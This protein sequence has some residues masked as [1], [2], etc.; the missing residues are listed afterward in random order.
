MIF[1]RGWIA[2][3]AVM[4]ACGVGG[5]RSASA[6]EM[7]KNVQ[8]VHIG[9]IDLSSI[10]TRANRAAMLDGLALDASPA[11][12]IARM[13]AVN[14]RLPATIASETTRA[15]LPP[16]V[17]GLKLA[18]GNLP[19]YSNF[20]GLDALD[21]DMVNPG[22][23]LGIEPPDQGLCVGDGMVV[24]I[25]N[26]AF[27]T[28]DMSG[29]LQPPMIDLN[30]L[31]GVSPAD[32]LSDP[33]CYYDKPSKTFFL[34]V[35]DLGASDP[36]N[37][38]WSMTSSL[39]IAVMPAGGSTIN[40]YKIDS[41]DPGNPLCPCFE[42]QPLLG[43]DEYGIYISGNEF[44]LS[45]VSLTDGALIFAIN[46]SDL[47]AGGAAGAAT[48]ASYTFAYSVQP[49]VPAQGVFDTSNNG[50]E[51]LMS[52]LD[53][54]ATS[55]DRIALWAITNTCGIPSGNGGAACNLTPQLSDPTIIKTMSY[56]L[57]SQ[58]QQ[59]R[60][61]FP[62]GQW[63]RNRF[64]TIDSGDDRMQQVVFAGGKLYAG[65]TTLL[66]V[67]GRPH[68]GILY[69]IVR[70]S[71]SAGAPIADSITAG[72]AALAGADLYY[73]SIAVNTNGSAVMAFSMSGPRHF[74][75]SAYMPLT[76]DLGAPAIHISRPG[77]APYD[78]ISG[79]PKYG[80]GPP[81]RWG[82]YSAAFADDNGNLWIASE[83]TGPSC[84]KREWLLDPTHT[85]WGTR[86]EYAN[87][88]TNIGEITV[89]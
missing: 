29:N 34:T 40:L 39:R 44:P 68:T 8:V 86:G 69:F 57:P 53:F 21:S 5:V 11:R 10:R 43:A 35:T 4:A 85:C 17:A 87:W 51:Y 49:A 24:E 42:D 47:I 83:Y 76:G 61:V 82:D 3:G 64:E 88:A 81:A 65:L 54:S 38:I 31:F 63:A 77:G 56:G 84:K 89:P 7:I 32:F 37:H 9:T 18:G 41:T 13:H 46:K 33:R 23:E 20:A 36:T 12:A 71:V 62:V 74:P 30:T 80:G 45:S 72:Y 15:P 75:S 25:V 66:K 22:A 1:K 50:T 73:P 14:R 52:S 6:A 59:K 16:V 78:G 70:P 48:F 60:G 55:D 27:A 58:A 2:A 28:Y 26:L 19:S 67:E 79:Y